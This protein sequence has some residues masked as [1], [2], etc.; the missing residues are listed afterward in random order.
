MCK[1]LR[2]TET[3][4]HAAVFS[5]AGSPLAFIALACF[6]VYYYVSTQTTMLANSEAPKVPIESAT[7]AQTTAAREARLKMY[8]TKSELTDKQRELLANMKKSK[9]S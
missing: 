1:Q 7:V 2:D 8:E 5:E 6:A 9:E 4:S 3:G